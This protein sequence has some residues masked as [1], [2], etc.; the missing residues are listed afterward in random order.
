MFLRLGSTLFLDDDPQTLH[1]C[2]SS[3]ERAFIAP[4]TIAAYIVLFGRERV[5]LYGTGRSP[6]WPAFVL[7]AQL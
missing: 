1:Q 3:A 4:Q 7:L 6:R 2:F 5:E